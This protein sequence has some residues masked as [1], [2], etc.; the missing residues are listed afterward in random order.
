M[1]TVKMVT[2]QKRG[3]YTAYGNQSMVSLEVKCG[4]HCDLIFLLF[5]D[6]HF[7]HRN[8]N[9]MSVWYYS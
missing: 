3:D 1:T 9:V 5:M 7:P 4:V 8:L 6:M 2:M